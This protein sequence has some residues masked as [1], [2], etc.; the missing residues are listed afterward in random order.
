[1]AAED[2]GGGEEEGRGGWEWGGGRL[3]RGKTGGITL[4]GEASLPLFH[5]TE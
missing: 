1:M 3:L 2:Q 5:P 4:P